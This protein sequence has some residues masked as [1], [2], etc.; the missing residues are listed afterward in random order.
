VIRKTIGLAIVSLMIASLIALMGS[1]ATVLAVNPENV[2]AKK[3]VEIIDRKMNAILR[4]ADKYGVEINE[5]LEENIG[6]AREI[7]SEAYSLANEKPREAIRKAFEAAKVFRPVAVHVLTS[8]PED[9]K[10][11]LRMEQLGKAI[12]FRE[13]AIEKISELVAFLENKVHVEI[14]E[15]VKNEVEILSESI[16]EIKTTVESGN[17]SI[18][19][20]KV[21]LNKVDANIAK[22]LVEINKVVKHRWETLAILDRSVCKFA[23]TLALIGKGMNVTANLISEGK[24]SEAKQL[25]NREIE[26]LSKVIDYV[27]RALEL[28]EKRGASENVTEML[29]NIKL[30]LVSAK[31]YLV[32]AYDFLENNDTLTALTLVS[33]ALNELLSIA[34]KYGETLRHMHGAVEKGE[35]ITREI[36]VRIERKVFEIA[37]TKAV[38][39]IVF[40]KSVDVRLNKLHRQY[41]EGALTSEEFKEK[42]ERIAGFLEMLKEKLSKLPKQ[43]KYIIDMID[44]LTEK[45]YGMLSEM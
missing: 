20:I 18:I 29:N 11:R 45:A 15:T 34:E 43:P 36:S 12:E 5:T 23:H 6:L 10:L 44:A 35:K 13:K 1:A 37:T 27:E 28:A 16:S 25:L 4:L 22:V 26:G 32:E 21:S 30:S 24:I 42:V 40:L 41:E 33:D 9:E 38:K 19:R 2:V 39:L 8:I 7:I 14:P 17:F 3:V 31:E